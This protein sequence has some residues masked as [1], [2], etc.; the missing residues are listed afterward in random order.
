MF[1]NSTIF[2]NII[3]SWMGKLCQLKCQETKYGD[4]QL[5]NY[6]TEMIFGI[7]SIPFF[8][9]KILIIVQEYIL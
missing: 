6:T 4:K 8:K 9:K 2:Q 1:A 7:C 5:L 3:Y